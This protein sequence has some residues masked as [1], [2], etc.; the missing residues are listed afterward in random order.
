MKKN[1]FIFTFFFLSVIC[2]GFSQN[3]KAKF[4]HVDYSSIMI[5]IPGVDTAQT[6][7]LEFKNELEI[8][9]EEMTKELTAKK[10]EFDKYA[11]SQNAN[12][13]I[14]KIRQD[15]LQ[16]MYLKLQDYTQS[17][18]EQL[19]NKQMELL[20]PLQ[21]RLLDAIKQ[22]AKFENYTYIFDISTLASYIHGDDLS[23]KVKEKLGIN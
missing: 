9:G 18:Q 3:T 22:V 13:A 15:E 17:S 8:I 21:Q 23:V 11:A 4:G 2:F 14:I 7:L 20:Q 6:L 19:Q 10:E 1:T 5:L 16:K 12:Q